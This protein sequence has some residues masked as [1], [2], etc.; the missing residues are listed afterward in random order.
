MLCFL[1]AELIVM[2]L[3]YDLINIM[4]FYVYRKELQDMGIVLNILIGIIKLF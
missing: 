3:N 2:V 1:K 4:A